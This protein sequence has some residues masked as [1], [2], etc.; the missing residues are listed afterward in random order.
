MSDAE[1]SVDCIYLAACA[2]D[3][4]LTRICV[5]SVRY[6]YPDVPI[7]IL[8]GD[9]LEK[10]LAV[11]LQKYWNVGVADLPVGD[12]GSGFV[13]L[14]PLFGPAGQ[15]FIVLDVDTVFAGKVLDHRA[16]SD[17]P[18]IVDDEELPDADLRRL[19]YDW[20]KLRDVDPKV[21]PARKAFNTGQWFGVAGLLKREDFD[22]WVEWTLPRRL[23]Y[24]DRFMTGDQGVQNY[25]MLQKEARGGLRVERRVLMRWPGHSMAGLDAA[26]IVA[27][28]APPLVIHWAGMKAMFLRNMAAGDVLRF[29]EAFYYSKL[30]LGRL[31]RVIGLWRH[32][33]INVSWE[34]GRRIRL[35]WRMWFGR[36]ARQSRPA[37]V[38]QSIGS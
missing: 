24:P 14:E 2:R 31:R 35:R 19:Y 5:A 34:I 33:W 25:V 11:E 15:R 23:T 16:Q 32:I 17:A 13:K 9:I 4:R 37:L 38:K 27:G 8:A 21:Q 30:P 6:F 22:P 26:S 7:K 36:R 18:F 10:G 28:A 3:G 29:F 20:D 12:F 1:K